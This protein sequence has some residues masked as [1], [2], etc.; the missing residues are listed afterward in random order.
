MTAVIFEY[1][2][3]IGKFVNV[4]AHDIVNIFI[5]HKHYYFY[6]RDLSV[7]LFL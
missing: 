7:A 1:V 2:W 6:G 5:N 3:L 4:N